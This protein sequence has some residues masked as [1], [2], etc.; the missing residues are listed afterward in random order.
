MR[1]LEPLQR[2]FTL[3]LRSLALFRINLALL[4]LGDLVAR[5]PAARAFLSDEGFFSRREYL[6]A[7]DRPWSLSLY[8]MVGEPAQ[9][10]LLMAL[11]GLCAVALLVG[12]RTRV[13]TV[14]VWVLSGSLLNRNPLAIN[15]GD[16]FYGLLLFWAMFLPLGARWSLDAVRAERRGAAP[17]ANPWCDWGGVGLVVQL[18]VMYWTTAALKSDAAWWEGTALAEAFQVDL[19]LK[20]LAY[21]LAGYPLLLRVL[22]WGTLALEYLGPALILL[23]RGQDRIRPL[24]IAAF[25]ALHLG[26]FFTM[27]LALFPW[28]C[29]AAWLALLPGATWDKAGVGRIAAAEGA[30]G[31]AQGVFSR[32]ACV[33]AIA[34]VLVWVARPVLPD[35]LE[36]QVTHDLHP[37]SRLFRL[38][39]G[40]S[41]FAPRPPRSDGWFILRARQANGDEVDLLTAGAPLTWE[42]PRYP[43]QTFDGR[44]WTKYL[45]NIGKGRYRELRAPFCDFFIG[46]W[47]RRHD[48]GFQIVEAELYYMRE[49]LARPDDPPEKR[50][51]W[52]R[53]NIEPILWRDPAE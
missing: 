45:S 46:E 47:N 38:R 4:S 15:G 39:Q 6:G 34:F 5:W 35:E 26:I 9:V 3:D 36:E 25:F 41:M 27:E 18:V 21:G 16:T 43:A 7:I 13:F 17:P 49:E 12:W 37:S 51:L 8:L 31:P 14:L 22:T 23:P 44:R 1:R 2:I 20:P 42:K 24:V 40:W 30:T 53:R 48:V 29:L 28:V 10:H 11:H 52:Y 19:L 50:R 33:V 32:V